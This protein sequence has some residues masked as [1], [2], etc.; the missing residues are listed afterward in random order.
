MSI[1]HPILYSFRRCPYAMR[2]RMALYQA[3][4]V[5][6]HRE[7]VLRNKPPQMLA[8]SPK[9]TIPVLITSQGKVIDESLDIMLWALSQNDPDGWIPDLHRA[10]I[11]ELIERNDGAFKRALDRY[12]YPNR[13][14]DEDCSNARADGIKILNDL[15]LRIK[16]NGALSGAKTTLADIAIFPFIRQFAH[17]DKDFF[18]RSELKN[19][20]NWLIYNTNCM[21]FKKAMTKRDEWIK[22]EH[23]HTLIID[24]K[25][26][27]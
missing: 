1:N 21:L 12:K 25:S 8:V 14:P 18:Y 24:Y 9:G 13:F 16:H 27:T 26:N 5:H 20:Q 15:E 2:A 7:I 3:Q 10:D 17:V 11:Y 22:N 19:L 23:H 4:I 6:E